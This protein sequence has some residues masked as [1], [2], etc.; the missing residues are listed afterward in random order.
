[1]NST[2]RARIEN[3]LYL[4]V[5]FPP[6]FPGLSTISNAESSLR[7]ICKRSYQEATQFLP[8]IR[9]QLARGTL[10]LP[11][12]NSRE[13]VD[14]R[15]SIRCPTA[16]LLQYGRESVSRRHARRCSRTAARVINFSHDAQNTRPDPHDGR[17]RSIGP[18]LCRCA[19]VYLWHADPR[20][21]EL[22]GVV[23]DR[24]SRMAL[25]AF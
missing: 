23:E 3:P 16:D 21:F 5:I 24:G 18:L 15:R 11:D 22:S 10:L 9:S 4:A 25:S 13:R 2:Q 17:H 20:L 8:S 1:M 19:P 6:A 7:I 12:G 14:G